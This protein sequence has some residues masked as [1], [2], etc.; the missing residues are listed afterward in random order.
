MLTQPIQGLRPASTTK[1][2]NL[3]ELSFPE[4]ESDHVCRDVVDG[5]HGHG[6]DVPDHA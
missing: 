3:D 4:E 6:H 1:T 5:D 2:R